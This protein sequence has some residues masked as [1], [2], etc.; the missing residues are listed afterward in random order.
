MK[1]KNWRKYYGYRRPT[2]TVVLSVADL[3]EKA[4]AYVEW[5]AAARKCTKEEAGEYAYAQAR[6]VVIEASNAIESDARAEEQLTW[7]YSIRTMKCATNGASD[8]YSPPH[9]NKKGEEIAGEWFKLGRSAG[10][11]TYAVMCDGRCVNSFLSK[12]RAKQ[13]TLARAETSL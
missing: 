1:P 10:V 8:H 3:A 11:T 2:F 12:A 5:L 6:G 13:W 7:S 4:R 9:V